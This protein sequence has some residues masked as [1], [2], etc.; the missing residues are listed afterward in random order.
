MRYLNTSLESKGK[1]VGALVAA[2]G[3]EILIAAGEQ[4]VAISFSKKGKLQAQIFATI[5][6][7][8]ATLPKEDEDGDPGRSSGAV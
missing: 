4:S 3:K 1:A 5:D 2:D 8:L 7:M 6:D